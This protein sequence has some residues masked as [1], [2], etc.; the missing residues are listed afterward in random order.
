MSAKRFYIPLVIVLTLSVVLLGMSYSKESGVSDYDAIV[1][2]SDGIKVIYESKNVFSS[3]VL[4]DLTKYLEVK[5]Y[6]F[7]IINLNKT[8]ENYYIKVDLGEADKDIKFY[9]SLDGKEPVLLSKDIILESTLEEYGS[10]GDYVTHS[11]RLFSDKA[12]DKS[13]SFSVKRSNINNLE[14][15]ILSGVNTYKD[16]DGNYRYYGDDVNNF[17]KYN[18]EIYRIIGLVDGKVRLVSEVKNNG[19]FDSNNES[20]TLKEYLG[21]FNNSNINVA[22]AMFYRNWLSTGVYWFNDMI[23]GTDNKYYLSYD[24]ILEDSSASYHSHRLILNLDND[25]V[26]N[27][28]DGTFNSPFEVSHE[29]K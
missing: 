5:E 29:S 11:L 13:V 12:Y 15:R 20:I 17:I 3:E 18:D 26:I 6:K 27:S 14:Y 2:K 22:S 10:N 21:A 25:L 8:K 9:Y 7:N 4:N 19:Q 1:S 28:G 23:E 24:N 16:S